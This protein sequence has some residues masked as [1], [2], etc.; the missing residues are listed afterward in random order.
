VAI[1]SR[2]WPEPVTTVAA[3]IGGRRDVP[4]AALSVVTRSGQVHPAVLTPAVVAVA[5]AIS[6]AVAAAGGPA[7][8]GV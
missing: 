8:Y 6:R 3:P 2:D 1:M 4:V 7:R 5:R